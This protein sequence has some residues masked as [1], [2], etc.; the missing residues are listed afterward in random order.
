M[1]QK[2]FAN[3][4]VIVLLLVIIAG[5]VGYLAFFRE[6]G[7]SPTTTSTSSATPSLSGDQKSIVADSKVLLVIDDDAIFNFFKTE[8][9]LCDENNINSTPDRRMFCEN[10]ATFKSET[11]FASIVSSPDK[12]KIGLTI[13]SDALTP[14]K[15]VGI[16]YPYR[17]TNKIHFLTSYY[18]LNEFISFSPSGTNFVFKGGCFEG[19]CGLYIK[20]S[21]TL[22]NKAGLSDSE[23][24]DARTRN[25]T[26]VRWVSDNEVEYK[27]GTELKRASF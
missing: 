17:T 27:L 19:M 23:S 2:G 8:S 12:T 21:E 26:F 20:N 14:D 7:S 24:A 1:N 9:Q 15:V 16:F 11:R 18:L 5:V 3:T 6:K 25:A 22:V 13:E 4:L 10:K